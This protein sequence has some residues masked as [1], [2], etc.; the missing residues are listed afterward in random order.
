MRIRQRLQEEY[1]DRGTPSKAESSKKAKAKKKTPRSVVDTEAGT[2]PAEGA[3]TSG[4]G[5]GFLAND[6]ELEDRHGEGH[7]GGF[8][9]EADDVV[10][11]FNLPKY[12][13]LILESSSNP[14][15]SNSKL[16]KKHDAAVEEEGD[17]A[18]H[19]ESRAAIDYATYDL[20][21]L[22]DPP[23]FEGTMDVDMESEVGPGEGISLVE[24]VGPKTMQELLEA[25]SLSKQASRSPSVVEL[26]PTTAPATETLRIKLRARRKGTIGAIAGGATPFNLSTRPSRA[27]SA[28]KR[29]RAEVAED[30]EGSDEGHDGARDETASENE[31]NGD[32]AGAEVDRE[33]EDDAAFGSRKSPRKKKAGAA[34]APKQPRAPPKARTAKPKA[35]VAPPPPTDRVL[36]SRGTK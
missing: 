27:A 2:E 19:V 14:F 13:P 16:G 35:P 26:D 28:M 8:L 24:D 5:G 22:E 10:Q 11:A 3:V 34:P 30:D 18:G 25:D 9:V 20:D 32:D 12:N 1:A 6:D 23:L 33:D 21:E 17:N 7:G 31:E 36:R 29:K 15:A 4:S